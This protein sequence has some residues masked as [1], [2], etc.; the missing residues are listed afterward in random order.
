MLRNNP[1]RADFARRVDPVS[2]ARVIGLDPLDDYQLRFLES[3]NPRRI[4]LGGRQVGKSTVCSISAVSTLLQPGSTVLLLAPNL[5]TAQELHL[6]CLT[7][8]RALGRPVAT[9]AESTLSLSLSNRSRLLCIPGSNADGIRGFSA[10]EIFVDEAA[11]VSD[12]AFAAA[13]AMVSVTKG[14]ITPLSS[15]ASRSGFFWNEWSG[16]APWERYSIRS[17]ECPRVSAEWLAEERRSLPEV[18]YK[19]EHECVFIPFGATSLFSDGDLEN[20]TDP[21]IQPLGG[22]WG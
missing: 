3:T 15:A 9:D 13:R 12:E 11:R 8:Y 6:K 4:L 14:K 21:R 18:I 5:R 10:T 19:A 20:M 7:L 17:D 16:S 1:L 2:L 22:D